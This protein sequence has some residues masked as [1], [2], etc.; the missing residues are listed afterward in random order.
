LL[1]ITDDADEWID[2]FDWDLDDVDVL[3][4][5]LRKKHFHRSAWCKGR[6]GIW[7]ACDAYVIAYDHVEYV[8]DASCLR[9][10]VKFGMLQNGAVC[11]VVSCH[12][13]EV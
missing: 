7:V 12:P 3:I 10:Y 4:C 13:E 8:E 2:K 9:Y 11:A 6:S 1:A 5:A